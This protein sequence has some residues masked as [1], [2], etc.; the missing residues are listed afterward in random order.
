VNEVS[1][2]NVNDRCPSDKGTLG[3]YYS[4]LSEMPV[5]HFVLVN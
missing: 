2:R 5:P 1:V 3:Q 4:P